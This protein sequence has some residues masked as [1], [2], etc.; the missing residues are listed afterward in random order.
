M[1]AELYVHPECKAQAHLQI[2]QFNPLKRDNTDGILDLL[3]YMPKVVELYGEFVMSLGVIE[4]EYWGQV[5]MTDELTSSC[6]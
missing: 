5:E 3:T 4:A 2:S 6:F 1:A